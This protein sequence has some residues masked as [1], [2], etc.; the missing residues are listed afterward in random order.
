MP[1]KTFAHRYSLGI[2]TGTYTWGNTTERKALWRGDSFQLPTK[3]L[4][5]A[6]DWS[7]MQSGIFPNTW[8]WLFFFRERKANKQ[9]KDPIRYD[10]AI[11]FLQPGKLKLCHSV[12]SSMTELSKSRRECVQSTYFKTLR[13]TLVGN[14]KAQR[15]E[16]KR[17]P[18]GREGRKGGGV[19]EK[20]GWGW[21]GGRVQS[22]S[23]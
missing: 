15:R 13:Q 20:E 11:S 1:F 5:M 3:F 23:C 2:P 19:G 17:E 10:K 4:S 12:C 9:T 7:W 22:L 18:G 6:S 14:K 16:D 21:R 8:G